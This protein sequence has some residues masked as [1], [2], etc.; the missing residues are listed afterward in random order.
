MLPTRS[1][2]KVSPASITTESLLIPIDYAHTP[3]IR[4]LNASENHVRWL[5]CM[6]EPVQVIV[7]ATLNFLDIF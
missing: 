7:D 5:R 1:R 6:V 2:G 4:S 3:G